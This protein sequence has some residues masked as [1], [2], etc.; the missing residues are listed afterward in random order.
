MVKFAHSA[1]VAQGSQD[2]IPGADLAPVVKPCCGGISHKA[3]ERLAQM[4]AQRQSSSHT[5]THTHT[6]TKPP[7]KYC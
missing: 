6:H 1:L 5:H 2:W 4:L 7:D 3:E